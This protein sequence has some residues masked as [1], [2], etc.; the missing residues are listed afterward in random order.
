MLS[1]VHRFEEIDAAAKI[2]DVVQVPAFLCRQTDFIV[3]IAKKARVINIK[4]GQFWL[5]GMSPIS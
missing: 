1:D 2:L 4:K 3:D 5:P